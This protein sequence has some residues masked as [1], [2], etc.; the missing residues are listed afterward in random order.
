MLR[1]AKARLGFVPDMYG[2][3]ANDPTILGGCMRSHDALRATGG[4]TPAA[5]EEW[6]LRP[7]AASAIA[8]AASRRVP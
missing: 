7:S 3:M 1:T 8:P 6:S 2:Q 5:Q 4:F